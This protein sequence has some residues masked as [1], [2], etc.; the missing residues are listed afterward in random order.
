M[1]QANLHTDWNQSHMFV[2]LY[3]TLSTRF[4]FCVLIRFA[5]KSTRLWCANERLPTTKNYCFWHIYNMQKSNGNEH[6]N[7][8]VFS[9]YPIIGKNNLLFFRGLFSSLGIWSPEKLRDWSW[10]LVDP[11]CQLEQNLWYCQPFIY[12]DITWYLQREDNF[13]LRI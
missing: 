5:S 10:S 7:I 9:E 1:Y 12:H 4:K 3:C 13:V 2:D 6:H 8:N 11:F